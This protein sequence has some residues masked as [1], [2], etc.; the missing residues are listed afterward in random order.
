VSLLVTPDAVRALQAGTEKAYEMNPDTVRQLVEMA[1]ENQAQLDG[2][3][4]PVKRIF[5]SHDVVWGVWQ[6]H[7]EPDGVGMRLIKGQSLLQRIVD[8]RQ[9]EQ[10]R[11]TAIPCD[12]LEHAVAAQRALGEPDRDN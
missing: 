1:S 3:T 11:M 8:R 4:A 10:V 9:S 7:R 2:T 5:A 6:D 12:N